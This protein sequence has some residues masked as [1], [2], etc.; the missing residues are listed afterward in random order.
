MYIEEDEKVPN[1]V[2]KMEH[3]LKEGSCQKELKG[4]L[5]DSSG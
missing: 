5:K 4:E 2:T 3:T 1:D